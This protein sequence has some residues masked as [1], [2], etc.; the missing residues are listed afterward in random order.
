MPS[1]PLQGAQARPSEVLD[2]LVSRAPQ[3]LQI[4]GA[5][6]QIR[7]LQDEARE[8]AAESQR[9]RIN[10]NHNE[11]VNCWRHLRRPVARRYKYIIL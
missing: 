2:R 7:R 11:R 1:S 4:L 5:A 9:R 3:S 8:D 10:Y 6:G